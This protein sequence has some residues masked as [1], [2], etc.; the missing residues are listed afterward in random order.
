MYRATVAEAVLSD[1]VPL[2]GERL[3]VS[4]LFQDI[5]GFSAMS[6]SLDPAALLRLLNQ[7]FTEV[8]AAVEAEGG[9]VKQFTGDGVMAL[10]GAPQALPGSPATRGAR[11]AGNRR[12]TRRA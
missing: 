3:E 1:R 5:R 7:F 10:F 12:A 4:I 9:T 8:V 2:A 11:C 6:E